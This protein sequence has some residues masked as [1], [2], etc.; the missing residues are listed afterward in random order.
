MGDE[1]IYIGLYL[2]C[3]SNSVSDEYTG[4][5]AVRLLDTFIK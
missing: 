5:T 3:V 2:W 1:I 4:I